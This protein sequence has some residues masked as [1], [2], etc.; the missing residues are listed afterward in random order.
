MTDKVTLKD[1]VKGRVHFQYFRDGK[2]W[3]KCDNGFMFGV[4]TNDAGGATF[5]PEDKGI[6]F[7]RWI[8]PAVEE[9]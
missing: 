5:L 7:M 9:Q 6:L 2:L 1:C 3:Y 8:R 4:P